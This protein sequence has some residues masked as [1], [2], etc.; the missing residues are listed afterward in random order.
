ST[1]LQRDYGVA[2][3]RAIRA[4]LEQ[5][6]RAP[7][8]AVLVFA[9]QPVDFLPAPRLDDFAVTAADGAPVLE[10]AARSLP[11]HRLRALDQRLLQRSMSE[12]LSAQL[13][14]ICALPRLGSDGWDV[15]GS[16]VGARCR[17]AAQRPPRRRCNRCPARPRPRRAF[18][19][20]TCTSATRGRAVCAGLHCIA[21]GSC[22]AWC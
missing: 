2:S 6:Q 18:A 3:A 14:H 4:R 1:P 20:Q 13:M 9:V 16:N 10:A 21:R 17:P 8:T 5:L 15:A 19:L 22:G 12:N 11:R 7:T